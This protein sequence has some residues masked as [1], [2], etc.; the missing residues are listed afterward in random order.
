MTKLG[1]PPTVGPME[2]LAVFTFLLSLVCNS[3]APIVFEYELRTGPHTP[4]ALIRAEVFAP[5]PNEQPSQELESEEVPPSPRNEAPDIPEDQ[6]PHV[7]GRKGREKPYPVA[8]LPEQS[9]QLSAAFQSVLAGSEVIGSIDGPVSCATPIRR[10]GWLISTNKE[11]WRL[12]SEDGWKL[13]FETEDW[14][15][16]RCAI[17]S[18]GR[19]L[20][21]VDSEETR[22]L[23]NGKATPLNFYA[24]WMWPLNRGFLKSE[25]V[26]QGPYAGIPVIDN[27]DSILVRRFRK[28][29]TTLATVPGQLVDRFVVD[30]S[31]TMALCTLDQVHPDEY[32]LLSKTLAE[33]NLETGTI[34]KL[35]SW[36]SIH[37][38]A[39][40]KDKWLVSGQPSDGPKGIYTLERNTPNPQRE[41]LISEAS[42]KGIELKNGALL[43]CY[44]K[45][46]VGSVF[47]WTPLAVLNEFGPFCNPIYTQLL[48]QLGSD[49]APEAG[50][51]SVFESQAAFDRYFERANEHAVNQFGL[52]LPR[53][54]W[55][56]DQVFTNLNYDDQLSGS[57][58]ALVATL[59]T[60]SLCDQGAV[61]VEG[62]INPLDAFVYAED[63]R[64]TDHTFA[65]SPLTVT[66]Q[67]LLTEDGWWNPS[68]SL[69]EQAN[70]RKLLIGSHLASIQRAEASHESVPWRS[71]LPNWDADQ[72][73]AYLHE[74][75]RNF[76]LRKLVYQQLS[77]AQRRD[78]LAQVA[79]TMASS[80]TGTAL[81]YSAWLGAI[82]DSEPIRQHRLLE[83]AVALFPGDAALFVLLGM[84]YELDGDRMGAVHCY[85]QALEL[86]SWGDA[87]EAAS[88]ALDQMQL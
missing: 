50:L 16:E 9:E 7:V 15:F 21:C 64:G 62:P 85:E 12:N 28:Q 77:L 25:S 29:E 17:Q 5:A 19:T 80:E 68:E 11:L 82:K 60:Q 70:G 54:P 79:E 26:Y 40:A 84:H 52:V 71:E 66:Q 18:Q 78:V 8:E 75:G 22:Q 24:N 42:A 44:T 86:D 87:Y 37:F 51:L 59:L 61:I 14:A 81:D 55:E 74:H 69:L 58:L 47:V 6:T 48:N 36:P 67:S 38:L 57:G 13:E 35:G 76:H 31:E 88:F 3:K 34:N 43:F 72:V 56:V 39:S 23:K 30:R 83:E 73:T 27:S 10:G 33:V 65:I 46:S 2:T 1:S 20:D 32:W 4:A 53:E 63:T 49:A 41:L 45:P